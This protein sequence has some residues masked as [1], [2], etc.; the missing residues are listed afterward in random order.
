MV[1]ARGAKGPSPFAARPWRIEHL[2]K[3]ELNLDLRELQITADQHQNLPANEGLV[4][5]VLYMLDRF[6][7]G[8]EGHLLNVPRRSCAPGDQTA[9]FARR[10]CRQSLAQREEGAALAAANKR[11]S[12][13]LSK[14]EQMATLGKQLLRSSGK[15]AV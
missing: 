9:G 15:S 8:Q 7:W 5:D 2:V 6:A 1:N 12:N 10:H 14:Q 11:V 4:E 13:I 3:G